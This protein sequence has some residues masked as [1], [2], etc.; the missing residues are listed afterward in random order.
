MFA[1]T[2]FINPHDEMTLSESTMSKY[3]TIGNSHYAAPEL[4][5]IS[6]Y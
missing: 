6:D 4:S 3:E 2:R 1:V 5:K